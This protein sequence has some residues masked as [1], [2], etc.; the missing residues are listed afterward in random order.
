MDLFRNGVLDLMYLIRRRDHQWGPWMDVLAHGLL[1]SAHPGAGKSDD[2]QDD[3]ICVAGP[4]FH[5]VLATYGNILVVSRPLKDLMEA[6]SLTG[7]RFE[8]KRV[9]KAVR[10]PWGM[11]DLSQELPPT[12]FEANE[13]EDYIIE[14]EHDQSLL[15]EVPEYWQVFAEVFVNFEVERTV[16]RW[17]LTHKSYSVVGG[18]PLPAD[19]IALATNPGRPFFSQKAKD[20]LSTVCGPWI[21]WEK[22]PRDLSNLHDLE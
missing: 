10:I 6:Y 7:V 3:P 20:L 8:K 16:D 12:S 5:P 21:V 18:G 19:A 4:P 2:L 9:K 14:R 22:H 17:G 11:W 15:A 13:S 1:Y